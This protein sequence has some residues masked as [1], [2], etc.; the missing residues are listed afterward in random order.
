MSPGPARQYHNPQ[1][2]PCAKCGQAAIRHRVQHQPKG[3]DPCT[4]C[5]L[6]FSRHIRK[7]PRKDSSRTYYVG[8]D[9]EGQGKEDH[10][11]VMLA[12]ANEDR[13]L[14][15]AI[16]APPSGRL[17]TVQCLDF[18]LSIP[19]YAR[20]FAF[21]FNYDLTMM[22]RDLDNATLYR[23]MRPD[24]RR[25]PP[26]SPRFGPVPVK[27]NGYEI[28][29][30]SGRFS[31][32]KGKDR[33]VI[34][35]I[36]K[37]F[38]SKF[39]SALED[40]FKPDPKENIK[41]DPRWGEMGPVVE[42]MIAMKNQRG[43][44]DKLT[45]EQILDYC[46]DECAYMARL[47]A[48]LTDAHT[49]AGLELK[50]YYGAGS[51]ASAILKKLGIQD[52]VQE[53]PAKMS[54]AV[55]SAF[56]GGRFENSIIGRIPGPLWGYD[57]SSAYPYQLTFLPCLKCGKWRVTKSRADLDGPDVKAALVR[58]TLGKAPPGCVWGPFPFRMKDGSITFPSTSGGGWVWQDEFKQGERLYPHVKF[59]KAWVYR[60]TCKHKPFAQIPQYYLDRLR[61]GKEGPGI[62][63]KLGI[64]SVYGKLAQ[65]AGAFEERK[66]LFQCWIWAGMVTS[67]TRA[68]LLEL[69]GM[70]RNPANVL[71]V[72]T[73]GIY[74]RE[75]LD[76][77]KPHDTGTMT[78]Q[79]KPL[80]GWERKMVKQGMFAARPGIYF[81]QNPSERELKQ[82]RA[83]GVGR[84][85]VLQNWESLV[86][87]YEAHEPIFKLPAV[88]R[89]FGAKSSIRPR[90]LH[91]KATRAD[92]FEYIRSDTY[93]QWRPW[94]VDMS[95]NPLPKR[96][97]I[98][99]D[100]TLAIR[101]FGKQD[102]SMPYNRARSRLNEEAQ[103]LAAFVQML[104]EQPQG[105]DF[106]DFESTPD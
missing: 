64:N 36:F 104:T 100:S 9:G 59:Q 29:F 50:T 73:D 82:V 46:Y 16:E 98:N 2:D 35:D 58:Y 13:T 25:P 22:L 42:R 75:E 66:P 28:N 3:P 90:A 11:Y 1:G 86:A 18:I 101:A 37:F 103:G 14:K 57:I 99:A 88:T 70:H 5:D 79:Q 80:G 19:N 93:G 15:D 20:P 61:I 95:F 54:T 81:P 49:E 12:Y 39:T 55:A 78:A 47:T 6:P 89:F 84:M 34:W 23:L 72:A 60:T 52:E 97:C 8:I 24:L 31:V 62:V 7:A 17:T 33:Q 21:A 41:G 74:S 65:S 102:V 4:L 26:D 32:R 71:M 105:T 10:R 69:M 30:L 83:R 38:Q 76:A 40:W 67:G 44:F 48:K 68:Q 43:D 96:E 45:R 85:A 63:I 91:D 87:A 92:H 53:G 56:F 27:W 77:P 94:P 51:T 106:S